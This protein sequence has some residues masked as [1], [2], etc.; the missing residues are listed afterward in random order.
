MNKFTSLQ[1]FKK[2]INCSIIRAKLFVLLKNHVLSVDLASQVQILLA[3]DKYF[4]V[5]HLEAAILRRI[6]DAQLQC[7][8]TQIPEKN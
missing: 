8:C 7:H 4:H 6:R 3:T 1:Y 2:I 5:D